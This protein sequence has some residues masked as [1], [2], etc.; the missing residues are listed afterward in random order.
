MNKKNVTVI[1]ET[2][3]FKIMLICVLINAKSISCKLIELARRVGFHY[4]INN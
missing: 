2:L 1:N 3:N 4:S